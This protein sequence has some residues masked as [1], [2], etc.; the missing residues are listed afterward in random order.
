MNYP[1]HFITS[2]RAVTSGSANIRAYSTFP[3]P[4][5]LALSKWSNL[6]FLPSLSSYSSLGRRTSSLSYS[7][8]T[9]P[10][11]CYQGRAVH[12]YPRTLTPRIQGGRRR[13]WAS[14]IL[15][16]LCCCYRLPLVTRP[17][18][19]ARMVPYQRLEGRSRGWLRREL[20]AFPSITWRRSR[21][22]PALR[23]VTCTSRGVYPPR[24]CGY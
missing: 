21:Q 19:N 5:D 7:P 20:S 13:C 4:N 2:S 14:R 23:I 3:P 16:V 17:S 15:D 6:L 8:R 12:F 24:A 18:I 22:L 11:R 1:R 9:D 10:S